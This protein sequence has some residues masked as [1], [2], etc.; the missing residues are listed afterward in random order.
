MDTSGYDDFFN[1]ENNT[2]KKA[3][4]INKEKPK[5]SYYKKAAKPK[6]RVKIKDFNYLNNTLSLAATIIGFLLGI[7]FLIGKSIIWLTIK[8]IARLV[9]TVDTIKHGNKLK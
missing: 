7:A 1:S 4:T 9:F 8:A 3:K 6:E 2:I 5:S